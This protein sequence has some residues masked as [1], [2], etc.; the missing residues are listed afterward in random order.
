ML[1]VLVK[2]PLMGNLLAS[3]Y[4]IIRVLGQ[5]GMGTVYEAN[6]VQIGKRVAIKCLDRKFAQDEGIVT[7]FFREAQAAAS[8]GHRGI[9]DIYDIGV[10]D[11][12]TPFLVM[13]YLQG[14]SL[15]AAI[16]RL[17]VLS[18]AECSYIIC[19][20][21][22]ALEAAHSKGIVHRDLKP[23]NIFLLDSAQW[24]PDIKLLDFGIAR[25][26][27]QQQPEQRLTVTGSLLGTPFFM[28]PEQIQSFKD[29]DS[30]ADLWA[31]GVILY[32]GVTGK[33]PFSG[34]SY[35][36][37]FKN[38]LA[39]DLLSP[40]VHRPD[41]PQMFCD[42]VLKS[43]QRERTVRF[44]SAAEMLLALTPFIERD[45]MPRLSLPPMLAGSR[46]ARWRDDSG[47][48]VDPSGDE[49]IGCGPAL[50]Q[51]VSDPPPP[52]NVPNPGF[53]S[54]TGGPP[55]RA[56]SEASLSP[57]AFGSMAPP[58]SRSTLVVG[59]ALAAVLLLSIIGVTYFFA[60]RDEVTA[61]TAP[62]ADSVAPLTSEAAASD[63]DYEVVTISLSGVP[64]DAK[65]WLDGAEVDG[66]SLRIR[67]SQVLRQIEVRIPGRAEWK[68][69]IT[70]DQDR[71]YSVEISPLVDQAATSSAS[72]EIGEPPHRAGLD[73]SPSTASASS[74]IME[75]QREERHS[76][77]VEVSVSEDEGKLHREPTREDHGTDP[78]DHATA[79]PAFPSSPT[80]E[81]APVTKR[82]TGSRRPWAGEFSLE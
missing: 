42:V 76:T 36:E 27:D 63:P 2:E 60:A 45:S 14:E 1:V 40:A 24:P 20:V 65:V 67:R 15:G 6:H 53:P 5:G 56:I 69:M 17:K 43:L 46:S 16:K 61:P 77:K 32:L 19:Q 21:L 49:P 38:I 52:P 78:P 35:Y 55:L 59:S 54:S 82:R 12:G 31:I 9:I 57:R 64:D 8:I 80:P 28:A 41:L 4:Q 71:H 23:D 68:R 51:E 26:V 13:E 74:V 47:T 58:R 37:V 29:A 70:P 75:S 30:R 73:K 33:V 72:P 48:L 62:A 39:A 66:T 81:P 50:P 44:S 10:G 25:V 11:D 3:K 22:S 34:G 18:V 79:D 7:R